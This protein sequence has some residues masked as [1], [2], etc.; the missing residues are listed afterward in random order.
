MLMVAFIIS[1]STLFLF[2]GTLYVA[3]VQYKKMQ[4]LMCPWLTAAHEDN[5][6]SHWL[7]KQDSEITA[8][9]KP[10]TCQPKTLLP[11]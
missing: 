9:P 10:L 5:N 11:L 2:L 8:G 4:D 3:I 1:F 6:S 7:R